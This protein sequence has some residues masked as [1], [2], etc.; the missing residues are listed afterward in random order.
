MIRTLDDFSRLAKG[1]GPKKL[2][3]LA[4]EDEEFMKAVKESRQM[5]YINL[6]LSAMKKQ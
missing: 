2:A 3:V 4:P 6:Y 1:K 5:G